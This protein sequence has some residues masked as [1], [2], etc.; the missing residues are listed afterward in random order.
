MWV[1]NNTQAV[2]SDIEFIDGTI[3]FDIAPM[4]KGNFVAVIFRRASPTNHENIYFRIHRS[5]LYNALQYAPRIN[6]S[7]TW[8]LYPEFNSKIDLPRHEW[9]HVSVEV[10]GT[11]LEVFLNEQQQPAL[12]VARLRGTSSKGSVGFWGRVNDKPDEWAAGISN[13]SIRPRKP[14]SSQ[15]QT[16]RAGDDWLTSW[17]VADA[18]AATAEVEANASFR[19]DWIHMRDQKQLW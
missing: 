3:E 15:T 1:R 18:G 17:E 6:G 14:S 19:G 4:E 13:V 9:T 8:Q 12:S 11:R 10:T 5:G 7:S 2:R 16:S